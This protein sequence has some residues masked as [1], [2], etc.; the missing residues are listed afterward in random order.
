MH[1]IENESEH[2]N[3]EA[4]EELFLKNHKFL[5]MI[6]LKHVNDPY[7][8]EDIV[9]EFFIDF[10]ERRDVIQ[11]HTSFEGYASRSVRNKA[12]SWLRK[13][14][15]AARRV[16]D[17]NFPVSEDPI[18][19]AGEAA[20]REDLELQILKL[21]DQLPPERKKIFLLS[22]A[23]N[24]TYAQIAESLGISINTVKTQIVKA[25]SFLR[26]NAGYLLPS[27]ILLYSS[28]VS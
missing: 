18:E 10:W 21:I 13:N 9:Q 19:L 12:I 7:V 28:L 20:H 11:L 5:C 1:R 16:N 25:Y 15:T 24:L 8:A 6:A 26:T 23:G 27:F 3:Q 14:E 4:F 22:T 17:Y 2:L